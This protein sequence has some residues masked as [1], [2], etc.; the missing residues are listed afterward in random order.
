[1]SLRESI[2]GSPLLTQHCVHSKQ[3]HP[4]PK[5]DEPRRTLLVV[6]EI[7]HFSHVGLV[8]GLP[9]PSHDYYYFLSNLLYVIDFIKLYVLESRIQYLE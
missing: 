5:D 8:V 4:N 6:C 3:P 1:V 9:R 2:P 7:H